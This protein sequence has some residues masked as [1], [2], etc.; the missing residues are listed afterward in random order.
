[1]FSDAYMYAYLLGICLGEEM[2]HHGLCLALADIGKQ[3]SKEMPPVYEQVCCSVVSS[4][5]GLLSF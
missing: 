1:M 4:T 2:L 3:F 5:L